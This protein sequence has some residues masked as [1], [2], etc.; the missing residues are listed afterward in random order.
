M[1]NGQDIKRRRPTDE[2]SSGQSLTEMAIITPLLLLMLLGL[3]E[4]GWVLRGYL[5]LSNANREA[6]RFAARGRYLDFNQTAPEAIGYGFVISQTTN[7]LAGQLPVDLSSSSAN[8][9]EI[10]SHYLVDTR[11]PCAN[12]STCV[13]PTDAADFDAANAGNIADYDDVIQ[14]PTSFWDNH[15]AW[16]YFSRATLTSQIDEGALRKQLIDE[17]N[18]LNC[19]MYKNDSSM[20]WSINS[21]VVTE[22]F[23]DQPQLTGIFD[24]RTVFS[25]SIIPNPI[26][27]YSQTKMRITADARSG[28]RTSGLGCAL[29]PI[30]LS[31]S[32]LVSRN[33]GEMI[34][35]IWNGYGYGQFGWLRWP[36]RTSAGNEGYLDESLNNP[37]LAYTD[38]EDACEAGDTAINAGDC[39]WGNSGI[40]NSSDIRA[41]L[42][43]LENQD[44][45]VPVWDT[46]SGTGANGYYRIAGFAIVRITDFDLTGT[47]NRIT[48]QFVR[49][50]NEACPGDGH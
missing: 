17:N 39:V 18:T 7:S 24:T 35:D 20:P 15:D 12:M 49:W 5:V 37:S 3:F 44:V 38:F 30:A 14:G 29:L 4:V 23:Y 9:G 13:C 47:Q 34:G 22:L 46:S 27:L 21:V 26:P 50:D 40:S 43:A 48:A 8:G 36:S 1:N 2:R 42:T 32:S 6:T 10:I 28:G 31:T 33:P 45:R 16:R 25:R 19:R 41:T 11:Q